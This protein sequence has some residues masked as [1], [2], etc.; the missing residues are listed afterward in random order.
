MQWGED[1]IPKTLGPYAILRRLAVG[2]MA[3]VFIG[4]A[5]GVSGFEKLVAL[6]L[7][8]P[9]HAEDDTFINMLIDEAKI[10]VRLNHANIVQTFDLG[11]TAGK[12]Y[13]VMEYVDGADLSKIIQQSKKQNKAIPLEIAA[14][15][16]AEVCKGL[17]HAHRKKGDDGKP[18]G[19]IHRDISP[20]NVL[21]SF[22]GEVKLADFGIAKAALRHAQ[23]Q[24][25]AIKGKYFYMSPEQAWGDTLDGRSDVFAA[26]ILLYEL[27]TAEP[28]YPDVSLAELIDKVRNAHIPDIRQKRK[29]VPD[30]LAQVIGRAL[31]KDP[32]ERFSTAGAFAEAL[33][34]FVY[35]QNHVS[36]QTV[37]SLM[38]AL[39]PNLD[40]HPLQLSTID[41][42][43]I[44]QR[45]LAKTPASPLSTSGNRSAKQTP[46][47]I[48]EEMKR[49]RMKRDDFMPDSQ[50]VIFRKSDLDSSMPPPR[51][52]EPKQGTF[53]APIEDMESSPT[54]VLIQDPVLR[55][56]SIRVPAMQPSPSSSASVS[57]ETIAAPPPS[58]GSRF[59]L[60][61]K[62][63]TLLGVT[64]L[65]LLLTLGVIAAVLSLLKPKTSS[66]SFHTI[67]DGASVTLVSANS[68]PIH[69][70]SPWTIEHLLQ[71]TAYHYKIEK[72]G[73]KTREGDI[74]IRESAQEHTVMLEEQLLTL[75][76]QTSPPIVDLYLDGILRGK[77]PLLLEGLRAGQMISLRFTAQGHQTLEQNVMVEDVGVLEFTLKPR[78]R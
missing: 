5:G 72:P 3:E 6:K 29:H 49:N 34:R 47:P 26:G 70:K 42:Q 9:T 63:K 76:V 11:C 15:I 75:K 60:T 73:Y 71:E 4:K 57:L 51:K 52:P 13:I 54:T 40:A 56:S 24:A 33:L 27:I 8:H 50:S 25:G 78:K 44:S 20:H 36:E 46:P 18:L 22:E 1:S 14:Y 61:P 12:Y 23:T 28:A 58:L 67:P 64:L 74:T 48:T 17:D 7:I 41:S 10:T 68:A 38:A 39:Y 16:V 69:G 53:D 55:S 62:L 21:L 45:P 2:G 31:A 65:G 37:A 32:K 30:A 77:T 35:S 66:L 43:K 19:I 59:K